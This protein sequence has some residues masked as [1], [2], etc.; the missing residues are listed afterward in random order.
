VPAA[1]EISVIV[2]AYRRREYL[3]E[4]VRSVQAQTVGRERVE[5]VV[6]KDFADPA[7]EAELTRAGI[8][9]TTDDDPGI[10]TWLRRAIAR[11]KAPLLAFLDDDD[12]YEPDR[13]ARVLAVLREHPEVG[14]YRNRVQVVDASGAP[15]PSAGWPPVWKDAAFDRS[16]P[17]I[18][19]P[20]GK[21]DLLRFSTATTRITF[22]SSTMVVRR[23]LLDGALGE[24]FDRS[25]L[26]DL[27]LFLAGALGPSGLF[28]DDRRL[29][30]YRHYPGNVT[31]QVRWLRAAARCHREAAELAARLGRDDF[32]RYHAERGEHWERLYRAGLITDDVRLAASRRAIAGHALDYLHFLGQPRR[33]RAGPLD[34]WAPALYALAYLLAPRPTARLRQARAS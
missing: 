34:L 33:E 9:W 10:G 15:I 13:L 18:V 11:T 27:A 17:V 31:R 32:A 30:R 24:L 3:L 5:I 29:T 8:A 14:F 26:P 6:T 19:P 22:N 25:Q 4:A 23:E 20:D 7:I 28:L 21:A 12:L 2:G 16:G 1:P